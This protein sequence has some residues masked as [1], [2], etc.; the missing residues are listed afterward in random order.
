MVAVT[1]GACVATRTPIATATSAT[2]PAITIVTRDLRGA[3]VVDGADDCVMAGR[4]SLLAAGDVALGS[5]CAL[6]ALAAASLCLLASSSAIAR[7]AISGASSDQTI[8]VPPLCFTDGDGDGDAIAVSA[9]VFASAGVGGPTFSRG[10][11]PVIGE[12]GI[13]ATGYPP[14]R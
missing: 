10:C 6:A 14:L 13:L 12:V 9:C 1:A 3:G 7:L 11:G 8:G 2:A 4:L 5:A